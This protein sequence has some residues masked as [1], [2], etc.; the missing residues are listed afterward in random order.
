MTQ[1]VLNTLRNF[2]SSN[3]AFCAALK[4]DRIEI[5]NNII[6]ELIIYYFTLNKDILKFLP[7]HQQQ[8]IIELIDKQN[9]T[10]GENN[11]Q[12]GNHFISLDYLKQ[13]VLEIENKIK[14]SLKGHIIY[15]ND[16]PNK[17]LRIKAY[18]NQPSK[19]RVIPL[20]GTHER[21]YT[22]VERA[23]EYEKT[24]EV[25]SK[26]KPY[27]RE[28]K[29]NYLALVNDIVHKAVTDTLDNYSIKYLKVIASYLQLYPFTTYIGDK[30]HI[31]YE[32]L[33]INQ[34]KIAIRKTTHN[35]PQVTRLKKELIS[36]LRYQEQL[37]YDQELETHYFKEKVHQLTIT[38]QQML[39]LN[40]S[41][42]R[43]MLEIYEL[44]HS[45]QVYNRNLIE[46][47]ASSFEEGTVSINRFFANPLLRI[48]LTDD[49]QSY[50]HCSIHLETLFNL[51]D[52]NLLLTEIE[53]QKVLRL[54]T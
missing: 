7:S 25:T 46:H 28:T 47:L 39:D 11:I 43:T 4:Q 5:D 6:I 22:L 32:V 34:S 48:F 15:L 3:N 49:N 12:I 40:K 42:L 51:V 52:S 10:I 23:N 19:Y 53:N 33:T 21:Y 14:P 20:E 29:D 54:I 9:F 50:F 13:L 18:S 41:K 26:T 1:K 45:P 30:I 36:L 16:L 38:E 31:P 2:I 24:T 35:H 17:E 37:E 44:E 27:I 8:L